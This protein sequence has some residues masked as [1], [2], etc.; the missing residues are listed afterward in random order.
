M[1]SRK[2]LEVEIKNLIDV[3]IDGNLYLLMRF[4]RGLIKSQQSN[5]QVTNH[6]GTQ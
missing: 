1:L 4:A 6:P 2:E 5:I 3:L